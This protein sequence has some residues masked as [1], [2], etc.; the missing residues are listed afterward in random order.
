MAA[1]LLRSRHSEILEPLWV[2]DW[3][4]VC[5][6]PTRYLRHAICSLDSR[7][8]TRVYRCALVRVASCMA[9]TPDR[10]LIAQ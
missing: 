7:G 10:E 6:V 5:L 3:Q 9:I 1:P 2:V 4:L 8:K